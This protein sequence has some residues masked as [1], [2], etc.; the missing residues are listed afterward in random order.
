MCCATTWAERLPCKKEA[1]NP[2]LVWSLQ[3]ITWTQKNLQMKEKCSCVAT[4]SSNMFGC[5]KVRPL[6]PKNTIPTIKHGGDSISLWGC[7]AASGSGAQILQD[8]LELSARRLGLG[9]SWVFEQDNDPKH[10]SKSRCR[11]CHWSWRLS[12]QVYIN[13][14]LYMKIHNC[15]QRPHLWGLPC[16]S[17]L[18]PSWLSFF[19][20]IL[21]PTF[22]SVFSVTPILLRVPP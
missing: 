9:S 20:Y 18:F 8:N 21:S 11:K 13:F 16:L 22:F 15:S 4:M 19:S 5:E 10:P 7:F 12:L 2:K 3:L 17:T 1:P 14:R 6:N